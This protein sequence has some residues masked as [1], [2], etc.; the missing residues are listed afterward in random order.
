MELSPLDVLK[1]LGDMGH[2]PSESYSDLL[3]SVKASE[4]KTCSMNMKETINCL[5][6]I[7]LEP[8]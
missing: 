3:P 1:C 8:K 7:S 4:K 5:N 6:E 2:V